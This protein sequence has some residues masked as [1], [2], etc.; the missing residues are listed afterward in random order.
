M[1]GKRG[2]DVSYVSKPVDERK[3]HLVDFIAT[4]RCGW[5]YGPGIQTDVVQQVKFHRT[6]IKH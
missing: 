5:K 2:D 1:A 3:Q 6:S 4:C